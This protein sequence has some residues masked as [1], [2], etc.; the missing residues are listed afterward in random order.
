MLASASLYLLLSY[1]LCLSLHFS[2]QVLL[3]KSFNLTWL[4]LYVFYDEHI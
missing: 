3:I 4:F 1:F 2:V